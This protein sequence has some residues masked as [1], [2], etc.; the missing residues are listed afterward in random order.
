MNN[1]LEITGERIR[2]SDIARAAYDFDIHVRLGQ[3]ACESIVASRNLLDDLLLQGK[4]I[5]GVNTS[6]GGFVKYL[7][8]EKYATQTQ[9]NL[10]AAV[11]TNVGPYFDDSVVRATMLTR[12]NSLA[13]GVS[14]ISLENIQKF[15][16]IFNKGICPCIPQKGSLG[17]SGDLG[18]LAAI[19]LALTG[20]WKVR[21]QG[22]IMS[23]SDAL[24]KTN[25]EPLRLSYKEGLALING[26]SAMT[27]LACLMVN[28]VEKLIK[29]Y[30]SITAL[31]LE[32][33]KGKRKVFSPL[34]HE[35]KPHRGQQASAANIYNAL[36]DSNMISSED[37][38]SKNLRSQ[39]F[40]NVIDSVA[41]QIEDA[42]SLRC[43][44]Q[45]IGPIRDAVDYV[46]CVVE[47]ELNSSNDNPLVIPKH[48]DVYHNG[49]FHGQYISMAMD[50]LSIALVTLSN[51][52]DRRIDRFMD[53]NNSNGLPPFLCANEQ[54]I[55][56]GLMG[57]Q[58][59]SASLASE[60]R[61]L[62]V[63]VSIHSLPSTADFQD[64]VSLGLVAARRAQEIFN[65]TVYVISFELLCACQAADIRGADKLGTHTAML[66]NSVRSFL[67][68]F[69]KDE[70]LTPYL[71]N[72]A[73]FIRNEM[74]QSLG[75]TDSHVV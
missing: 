25:I 52:S 74:A 60:N 14:A 73:M 22:E 45:I 13:R 40:D 23:A 1:M 2:A 66:Y 36:A 57:G 42:Y 32:T 75:A 26:T 20:K 63:P 48:G 15:V 19:A 7:I 35:E 11:A 69:E 49:H 72:I 50:H 16:E 27:G 28:D 43:T 38:V 39:L 61:S 47:N 34:V 12:I 55:R 8:P 71:E 68:F 33:L 64:I 53:K 10:I 62:C 67:P 29:S 24:R 31:A 3:K 46:K 58:F 51:L 37:D 56:L 59:M 6:M 5:Y 54:G 21:Y 70:S 30:E 9:E 41:D 4:V 44:P 65:N 18:P 17:T